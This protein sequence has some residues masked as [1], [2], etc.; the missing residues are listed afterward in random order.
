MSERAYN[1]TFDDMIN[2]KLGQYY[3]SWE[4]ACD[5]ADISIGMTSWP[6]FIYSAM[7]TCQWIAAHPGCSVLDIIGGL[8]SKP[9]YNLPEKAEAIDIALDIL[10][11][12]KLVYPRVTPT[13]D[14]TWYP[15]I[16]KPE[17]GA[18]DHG[19]SQGRHDA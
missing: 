13:C 1:K 16:P 10:L 18:A 8:Y 17:I 12:Q 11:N 3:E 7:L 15:R 19:R 14:I 6:D 4:R 5:E 9:I 2:E